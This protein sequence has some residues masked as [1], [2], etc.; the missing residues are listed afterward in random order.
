MESL[1]EL[2]E[3]VGKNMRDV[4]FVKNLFLHDYII[5]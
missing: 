5:S 2:L 1:E 4:L 3:I